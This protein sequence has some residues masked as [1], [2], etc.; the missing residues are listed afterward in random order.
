MVFFVSLLPSLGAPSVKGSTEMHIDTSPEIYRISFNQV[1]KKLGL[2]RSQL[3]ALLENDETF[4][5][6]NASSQCSRQAR[7]FFLG[8]EIDAWIL[9]DFGR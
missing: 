3:Y 1:A 6:P 9:K 5:R 8:H 2:S 7:V 4:P